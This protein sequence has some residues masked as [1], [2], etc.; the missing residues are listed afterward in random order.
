MSETTK[1]PTDNGYYADMEDKWADNYPSTETVADYEAF[2]T[3]MGG[4]RPADFA[5]ELSARFDQMRELR[6]AG[7]VFGLYSL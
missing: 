6:T 7:Y 1:S 2:W 3:E 4:D 5:A